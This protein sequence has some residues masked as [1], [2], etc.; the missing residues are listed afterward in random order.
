VLSPQFVKIVNCYLREYV[1]PATSAKTID[2]FLSPYYI[3][4]IENLIA[5]VRPDTALG[6]APELP[7]IEA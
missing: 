4:C 1:R 3:W 6:E 5:A 2:V 7:K